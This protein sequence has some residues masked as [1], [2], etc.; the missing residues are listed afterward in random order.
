MVTLV[1]AL[2]IIAFGNSPT[3]DTSLRF[4]GEAS[5]LTAR[6]LVM[7]GTDRVLASCVHIPAEMK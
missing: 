2:V 4:P 5:C 7:K 1:Y 3:I 6:A